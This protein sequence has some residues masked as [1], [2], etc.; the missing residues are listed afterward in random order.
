MSIRVSVQID[1][2]AIKRLA[3]SPDGE[4]GRQVE[5]RVRQVEQIAKVRAPVDTGTLRREIYIDGPHIRA[6]TVAWDVVAAVA[7][8]MWI[9]RGYREY[10][11]GTGQYVRARAGPRPFLLEALRQVFG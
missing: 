1:E 8:A 4:I 10:R 3:L 2:A 6:S 5:T 11:R 7:Y 9:H